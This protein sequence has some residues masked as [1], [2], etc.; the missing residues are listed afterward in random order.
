MSE[1]A[2]SAK[3]VKP[4]KAAAKKPQVKVRDLKPK[5]D[6]KG[7]IIAHE[8]VHVVNQTKNHNDTLVSDN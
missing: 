7:G 5:K 2:K 6:P 1:K 4:D 8:S 3:A